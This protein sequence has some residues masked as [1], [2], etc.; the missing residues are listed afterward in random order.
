MTAGDLMNYDLVKEINSASM[1]NNMPAMYMEIEL[2]ESSAFSSPAHAKKVL[3]N[4]M[5]L[6][7]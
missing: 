4:L 6:G 7:V 2:T 1:Q 5:N 3:T